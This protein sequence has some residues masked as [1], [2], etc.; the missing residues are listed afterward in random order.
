MLGWRGGPRPSSYAREEQ[1]SSLNGHARDCHNP[2]MLPT[3][4]Q[5]LTFAVR[6]FRRSPA[7]TLSVIFTLAFGIGVTTA[8]FSLVDG[9]LPR[10]LPFPGVRASRRHQHAGVCPGVPPTN[11]AAAGDCIGPSRRKKSR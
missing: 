3:L 7:F 8:I 2:F 11:L 4:H 1:L 6:Q 9:I 5:D 10:P